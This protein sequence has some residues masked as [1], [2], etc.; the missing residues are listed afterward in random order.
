MNNYYYNEK[1]TKSLH[2]NKLNRLNYCLLCNH[3]NHT[4][5][6][7]ESEVCNN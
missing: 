1:H 4:Y 6:E 2:L 3:F 7:S 5:M